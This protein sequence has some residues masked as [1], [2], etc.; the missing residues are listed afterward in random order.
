MSSFAYRCPKTGLVEWAASV[1]A[2]RCT[3]CGEIHLAEPVGCPPREKGPPAIQVAHHKW[4]AAHQKRMTPRE[5]AK[6][7]EAAG[8]ANI[9]RREA[10]DMN[11]AAFETHTKTSTFAGQG[12]RG[13]PGVKPT[14]TAN[15]G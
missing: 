7:D 15:I 2:C 3:Y 1:G 6:A 10:K 13:R 12:Y 8:L 9:T 4:S 14:V 11:P 5:E